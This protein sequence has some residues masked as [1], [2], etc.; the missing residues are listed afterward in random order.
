M[1]KARHSA[2]A[3]KEMRRRASAVRVAQVQAESRRLRWTV[4]SNYLHERHTGAVPGASS[5]AALERHHVEPDR[6][7]TSGLSLAASPAGPR[8]AGRPAVLPVNRVTPR[9]RRLTRRG[10]GTRDRIVRG[11][12][13]HVPRRAFPPRR[14]MTFAEQAEPSS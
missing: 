12:H 13:A 5:P 8:R 4:A 14:S 10:A 7:A 3:I 1:W 2:A 6:D 11:S 9:T